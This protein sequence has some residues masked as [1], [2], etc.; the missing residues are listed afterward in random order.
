MWD[1]Y[2]ARMRPEEDWAARSI[3]QELR[4]EVVEHDDNSSPSM[5]DLSILYPDRPHGAVEVTAAADQESIKLGKLVYDGERWIVE[6]IAGGWSAGL[7]PTANMKRIRMELPALLHSLESQGIRD[8]QPEVHWEP[9]PHKEFI[10][11]LGIVHLAQHG[12][13]YP[14]SVYLTVEQ[15]SD[16]TGGMSP[17]DGRPLLDW[18]A[19]WLILPDGRQP[20]EARRLR[21]RRA[22]PVPDPA[23]LR[24]RA[25]RRRGPADA[26]RLAAPRH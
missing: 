1:A 21:R 12:T 14:G 23:E 3:S 6:D 9:G 16:R 11:S 8:P 19:G 15:D 13:D 26:R 17:T 20:R 22:T 24:R 10:R 18:L 5:F 25:L 4:V 2:P 7:H